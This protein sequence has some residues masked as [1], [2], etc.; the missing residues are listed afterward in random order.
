V[1]DPDRY[2]PA[3]TRTLAVGRGEVEVVDAAVRGPRPF[4][5]EER[6]ALPSSVTVR[7]GERDEH[8]DARVGP[9]LAGAVTLP[10]CVL[11]DQDV[12]GTEAAHGPVTDLDVD[13]A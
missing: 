11:G 3:A 9:N 8:G 6:V 1:R 12:A 4:G 5:A 13:G 2:H 10:G 7:S